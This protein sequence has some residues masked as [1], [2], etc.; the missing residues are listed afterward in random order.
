MLFFSAA[1]HPDKHSSL[2]AGLLGK[3]LIQY[4][5]IKHSGKWTKIKAGDTLQSGDTD[6]K[7]VY[8]RSQLILTGDFK[9]NKI[10]RSDSF[11]VALENAVKY[12][13]ERHGLPADGKVG[14]ATLRVLNT[15]IDKRINQLK[16]N[17]ERWREFDSVKSET[18]YILVNVAACKLFVFLNYYVFLSIRT[19]VWR[20]T[21]RTP[22]FKSAIS[23]IEF[24]PSWHVPPGIAKLDIMP[25]ILEDPTYLARNRMEV[26]YRDSSGTRR[27]VD[28]DTIDW[29][30][31]NIENLKYIFIQSPGESNALGKMKFMFPNKF[32]V[33]LHDT[34][35]RE[36]FEA[37]VPAF[38]SGCIRVE[39]AK[40]LALYL[41]QKENGWSYAKIDS[42][43]STGKTAR[44]DLS[45]II[46]VYVQYFTAWVD[47]NGNLNF[48]DDIY[49][50]DKIS[51]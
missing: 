33:Y 13:Q 37:A 21:R 36:L 14:A 22:V 6:E 9:E 26:F 15:S 20:P 3:F 47:D 48:R 46:P 24:N 1:K 38:S 35:S 11:D 34:P 40:D 10:L 31:V 12:F 18:K 41:L 4:L 19:N 7:I 30:T 23:Y 28:A 25:Q 32:R 2:Q 50:R 44:V 5:A 45:E 51:K 49:G 29:T 16:V 42:V 8:L 43:L 17:I 39:K 27:K